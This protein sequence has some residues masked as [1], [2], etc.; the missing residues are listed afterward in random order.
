MPEKL[1][2]HHIVPK[3]MGGSDED[4]NI[5]ELSREDHAIAHLILYKLYGFQADLRAAVLLNEQVPREGLVPWNKGLTKADPRIAKQAAKVSGK[6]N[7]MTGRP[8]HNK[9]KKNPWTSEWNRKNKVG[10]IPWNKGL[11]KD[12]YEDRKTSN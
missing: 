9:G 8:S 3:H 2:R 4:W 5:M 10:N 12:Q 6:G 1:H 7:G 11:T